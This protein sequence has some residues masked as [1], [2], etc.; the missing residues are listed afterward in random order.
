MLGGMDGSGGRVGK[1]LTER[2]D[3]GRLEEGV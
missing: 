1:L 2:L 3:L